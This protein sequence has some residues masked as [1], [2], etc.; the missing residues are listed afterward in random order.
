MIRGLT[1]EEVKTRKL[2]GQTNSI[3]TAT[4]KISDIIKKHTVTL[5]NIVI[6]LLAGTVFVFGNKRDTLFVL[7][8]IISTIIAIFNDLRAR[9]KINK[10]SLLSERPITVIRNNHLSEVKNSELVLG[11]IIR[12]SLGDQII[13]DSKLLEGSLEV[14]ESFLTGESNNIKKNPG[15]KLYSG[16]FVVSGTGFAKITAI[17]E[18]N[19]LAKILKNAKKIKQNRSQLFSTLEKI[20]KINSIILIPVAILLFLKQL[21]LDN[22]TLNSAVTSTAAAIVA[23]VPA[24]LILLTSSVLALSTIRLSKKHIVVNDFYAIETLARVDT[25]CLDKTGTLTTGN[26]KVE[27]IISLSKNSEQEIKDFIKILNTFSG[28]INA[29]SKALIKKFGK[30]LNAK[31]DDFYQFSS[32]KKYSGFKI[33]NTEFFLGAYDFITTDKS[34]KPDEEKYAE[35]YRVLTALKRQNNREEILGFV[36]LSDELR[37]N[38]KNLFTFFKQNDL[39][40]KI[41]SG[42]S[43]TTVQKIINSLELNLNN[44][45]D[46]S[47]HNSHTLPKTLAEDFDIFAR[48]TPEQ[49]QS[50][51][52]SLRASGHIVAM[53]G[54]GVNDVLALKESDCGISLGAGA[55]AARRVADIVLLDNDFS[56]ISHAVFEG[57]KTIN[58]VTRSSALFLSKT[59]FATILSVVFIF[60]DLRYPFSPLLMSFVNVIIIGIPSFILALEPNYARI[61]NN[62]KSHIIKNSVPSALATIFSVIT[63]AI[64]SNLLNFSWPETLSF[65]CVLVCLIGFLLILKISYPL[66][67]LRAFL[68]LTLILTLILIFVLHPLRTI[69][70]LE[71]LSLEKIPLLLILGAAS[72]LIFFLSSRLLSRRSF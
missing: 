28:D 55:D 66:N 58:N 46:L 62:F 48:V 37:K 47:D 41:I 23:M 32:D 33:Q 19:S 18:E 26:L 1:S 54:D 44:S 49:K 52:K 71:I 22:A 25:I 9:S 50:L 36:L 35:S 3:S 51:V 29:T 60:L 30:N 69:L 57:R 63:I 56:V 65:S 59:I 13:A 7:I 45:V 12:F 64:L 17:G 72:S 20:I 4:T 21:S 68:L 15:D 27:K 70:N 40:V 53:T 61:K 6:F 11:D 16:S 43:P 5:F 38:I 8:A 2:Q 34:K 14:N 42:D 39:K 24:G 67:R 10:L 31:V